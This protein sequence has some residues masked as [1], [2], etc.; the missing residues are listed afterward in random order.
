MDEIGTFTTFTEAFTTFFNAVRALVNKGT[1][2]QMLDT[3]CWIERGR[4]SGVQSMLGCGALDWYGS[5]D[6]A[7]SLGIMKD[8]KL[9]DPCPEV[10]DARA[11]R[12]FRYGTKL[13]REAQ[14][15]SE[16]GIQLL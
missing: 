7:Y 9:I 11:Q 4:P 10:D 6:L 15:L 1:S 12:V 5:R 13:L 8:G 3:S 14:E 16:D 2:Y